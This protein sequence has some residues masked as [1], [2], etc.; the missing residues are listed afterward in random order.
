MKGLHDKWF[1]HRHRPSQRGVSL[2]E[3]VLVIGLIGVLAAIAIPQFTDLLGPS[4]VTIARNLQETLNGAVHRFNQAN[5]ELTTSVV[6]S[7]ED[8]IAVLRTL[9]YR[10]PARPK[11]GSP[12]MRTDWS[13]TTSSASADYRIIWMGNL[14][15]LLEPGQSG[16]GIKVSFDGGDLGKPVV[17]P[18]G[19]TMAGQ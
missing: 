1:D 18:P 13:P 17:F 15:K 4:K 8:E 7:G 5:Y 16:T 12:Y 10:H 6:G 9:Q 3:L 11:P 2:V 14:Y 19:F